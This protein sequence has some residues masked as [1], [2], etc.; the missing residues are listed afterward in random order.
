MDGEE[1]MYEEIEDERNKI[2]HNEKLT[3]RDKNERRPAIITVLCV[4]VAVGSISTLLTLDSAL[5]KEFIEWFPAY[6]RITHSINLLG[7]LG[8]WL[9]KKWGVI[10]FLGN[11]LLNQIIISIYYSW[12]PL[13][14]IYP[15]IL[16]I[17][18][19]KNYSKLS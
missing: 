9:M 10:L 4:L 5:Y 13:L 6:L 17:V 7:V 15:I 1:V 19:Y 8:F 11:S 16:L 18:G 3:F 12:S 2:L 14:L